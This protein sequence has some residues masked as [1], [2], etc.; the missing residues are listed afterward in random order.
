KQHIDLAAGQEPQDPIEN[1]RLAEVT[2]YELD[3]CEL[4]HR[5]DVRR[6][7]ATASAHAAHRVLA[8]GAGRR[9]EIETH[10]A[11][12][13]QPR[14]TVDLFEL[15][16]GARAPARAL[17]LLHEG[18]GKVLLQPAG[19]APGTPLHQEVRLIDLDVLCQA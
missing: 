2:L 13:Q 11:R 1:L 18:I 9:T 3:A 10:R 16:H 6:Y 17:R 8:P 19:A 4:G 12:L 15:E 14:A 7:H 5:K